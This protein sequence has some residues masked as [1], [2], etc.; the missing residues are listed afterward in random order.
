MTSPLRQEFTQILLDQVRDGRY[1]SPTML[2]R[3]EAVIGD[4]ASAEE[5]VAGLLD[6]LAA[7]RFPSPM[8]LD[9]VAGLLA[10]LDAGA[11]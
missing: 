8:M 2:D 7:D 4:R 11:G 5:Y 6:L 10:V 3:I 1:P 9:R